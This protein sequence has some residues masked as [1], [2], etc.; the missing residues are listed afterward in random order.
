MAAATDEKP[1]ET[2][3]EY[4]EFMPN[5]GTDQITAAFRKECSG[6]TKPMLEACPLRRQETGIRAKSK[7]IRMSYS[8]V[9]GWL[10]RM[11][12]ADLER[13]FDKKHHDQKRQLDECAEH[14]IKFRRGN[15]AQHPNAGWVCQSILYFLPCRTMCR[16]IKTKLR[17]VL[18]E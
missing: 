13:R 15:S 1:E 12:D 14:A 18:V 5:V 16:R 3:P 7:R 17:S 10:V 11:K 2:I 4:M 9:R 6:K 8:T